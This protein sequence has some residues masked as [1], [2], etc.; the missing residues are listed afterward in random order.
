M[1]SESMLHGPLRY[2][3]AG[4]FAWSYSAWRDNLPLPS[5]R[6]NQPELFA[7]E[8]PAELVDETR[9]VVVAA[10]E[11]VPDGFSVPLKVE[12]KVGRT[13]AECK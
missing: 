3:L 12:V 4:A 2:V 5:R 6:A 8:L 11:S 7:L 13:W 9:R 10:M 1:T